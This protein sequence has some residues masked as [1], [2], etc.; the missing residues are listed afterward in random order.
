MD[1]SIIDQ[2]EKGGAKTREAIAG[3]DPATLRR[4]PEASWDAGKWTI[5]Q[6]LVHL[7]DA[8]TAFADRV[9]RIVAQENPVLQAW[10][11]NRFFD[12]LQYGEQSA[13]DAVSL[14]DLTRRQLARVLKKLPDADFHRVGQHSQAGRQTVVD[15]LTKANWHLDHH[16]TFIHDK[17]AKF[18]TT[19]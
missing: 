15:V 2:Y 13:E 17:R 1:R 12:R 11:E 16:L 18:K 9:R 6:V 5:A 4:V 7:Q 19:K 3:L 8:E 10:D 14:I